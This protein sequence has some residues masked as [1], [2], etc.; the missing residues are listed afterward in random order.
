MA[1][2]YIKWSSVHFQTILRV[3]NV[4][5]RLHLWSIVMSLHF[6]EVAVAVV[7]AVA[8]VVVLL[9]DCVTVG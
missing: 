4:T 3:V 6:V 8:F 7:V 5:I 9:C 1:T 2:R